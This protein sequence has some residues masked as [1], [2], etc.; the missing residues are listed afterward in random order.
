[1]LEIRLFGGFQVLVDGKAA[2]GLRSDS[3]RALLAFLCLEHGRPHLRSKLASMLRSEASEVEARNSLRTTLHRLRAALNKATPNG[4]NELLIVERNSIEWRHDPAQIKVDTFTFEQAYKEIESAPLSELEE[5]IT[6]YSSE[7]LSG[8]HLAGSSAFDDWVSIQQERFQQRIMQLMTSLGEQA[9]AREKWDV[10]IRASQRQLELESWHEAAF[11]RWMIAAAAKGERTVALALFD[12][13]SDALADNLGVSPGAETFALFEQIRDGQ[14][15]NRQ[16]TDA[17]IQRRKQLVRIGKLQPTLGRFIGRNSERAQLISLLSQPKTRLITLRGEGGIGKSTLAREVGLGVEDVFPDG[18]WF[19][20]LANSNPGEILTTI[21]DT[22]GINFHGTGNHLKALSNAL[23]NRKVLLILDNFEDVIDEALAVSSLLE[24]TQHLKIICT[25]REAL[26]L[27]EEWIFPLAGLATPMA[28]DDDVSAISSVQLFLEHAEQVGGVLDRSRKSLIAIA[29]ICRFVDGSPLGIEMAAG[30][31][32]QQTPEQLLLAIQESPDIL[33]SRQRNIPARQR[34]MRNVFTYSWNNLDTVHQQILTRLSL[35]NGRFSA[36][37]ANIIARASTFHLAELVDK[38]LLRIDGAYF[39]MHPLVRVFS[40]ENLPRNSP[41]YH[42]FSHHFL[43]WLSEQSASLMGADGRAIFRQLN[44]Q[45]DNIRQ[46][47]DI[48]VAQANFQ[49]LESTHHILVHMWILRGS[50]KE[51]IAIF[52]DAIERLQHTAD[53]ARICSKLQARLAHLYLQA[54]QHAEALAM[55]GATQSSE[56]GA[57][58]GWAYLSEGIALWQLGERAS[59]YT[60]ALFEHALSAFEQAND[61]PGMAFAMLQMSIAKW[62]NGEGEA[63]QKQLEEAQKLSHQAGDAW[64]EA[65]I[66]VRLSIITKSQNALK[67]S[68]YWGEKA[69]ALCERIDDLQTMASALNTLGDIAIAEKRYDDAQTHL[70]RAEKI[71][72]QLDLSQ[73]AIFTYFFLGDLYYRM[74]IEDECEL[75]LQQALEKTRQLENHWW[76]SEV[77]IA[78]ARLALDN[79]RTLTATQLA[80]RGV[81]LARSVGNKNALKLARGLLGDELPSR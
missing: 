81:E 43:T 6:R 53:A 61:L 21:A 5:L 13:C 38:A 19:V 23:A 7:L 77:L 4:V 74:G 65:V 1:M 41:S 42:A 27:R 31:M 78:Q 32:R 22:I 68:R 35:F 67:D 47:W 17:P 16:S 11:R 64:V 72:N 46:A 10:V 60:Y 59:P 28:D 54:N 56:Y 51:G 24:G 26:D 48:A 44:Q 36:E 9:L 66:L 34:S 58:L 76:E 79:G 30:W 52:Q 45:Y 33:S 69:L 18:I 57:T 80:Q 62:A 15:D 49:L 25:S 63:S 37:S 8:F 20:P 39:Q 75:A 40:A 12:R 14:P 70:R 3:A 50:L 73:I 71:N 29:D 2:Q 55:A